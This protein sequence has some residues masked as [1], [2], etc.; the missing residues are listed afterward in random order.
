MNAPPIN[1]WAKNNPEKA[2]KSRS[3]GGKNSSK[4][5][6]ENRD[7]RQ[8]L[9]LLLSMDLTTKTGE[10]MSGAQ[11]MATKAFQEAIKGDWKAWE[12]VRDTAGQKPVEKMVVSEVDAETIAEVERMIEDA[13]ENRKPDD[14]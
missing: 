1:E 12:L 8:Y 3:S 6:K 4:K 10:K 13:K 7:I 5:R 9:E 11:A 2:K 14:E